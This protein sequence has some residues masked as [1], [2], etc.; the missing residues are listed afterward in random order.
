[1]N[2]AIV[3]NGP[4]NS[5]L[6]DDIEKADFIVRFNSPPRE[7][8]YAGM[9]TDQLIISNSSR[10]TQGLLCSSMFLEGPVFVGSRSIL[11]PYHPDIIQKYMPKPNFFSWLRGRRSDLTGLCERVAQLNSKPIG[12]VDPITYFDACEQLGITTALKH[13]IFPSSGIISIFHYLHQFE[14]PDLCIHLFGFGFFGWKRHDWI[15]EKNYVET[16]V[17]KG[18][19]KVGRK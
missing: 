2:I 6:F 17:N 7:H 8:E 19:V 1:M 11:L 15:A 16:L 9:R 5:A 10:Q 14:D 13:S 12:I 18:V 3:G 4:L